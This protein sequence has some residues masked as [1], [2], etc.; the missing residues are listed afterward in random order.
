MWSAFSCPAAAPKNSSRFFRKASR[1]AGARRKKRAAEEELE[2]IIRE[3]E[4]LE[5]AIER[6]RLTI[7]HHM[8]WLRFK[9]AWLQLRLQQKAYDPKQPR[10]PK[11][12][13][14]A[15]EWTDGDRGV[16]AGDPTEFSGARRDRALGH[17]Y[18][19]QSF[20]TT[21]RFHRDPKGIRGEYN[22]TASRAIKQQVRYA[23]SDL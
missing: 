6:K 8:A 9:R 2:A 16:G 10:V 12:N 3:R 13:P 11:A 19:H 1:S 18:V 22:R 21:S 23:P 15:G 5:Q 17:H 20:T 14:G 4:Q 7:K